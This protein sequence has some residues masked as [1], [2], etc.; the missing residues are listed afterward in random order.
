MRQIASISG[1][2]IVTSHHLITL[3]YSVEIKNLTSKQPGIASTIDAA[4]TE[5][6]IT[7]L[8]PASWYAIKIV[9]S[10]SAG[11][12]SIELKVSTLTRD[13]CKWA[14]SNHLCIFLTP[15]LLSI[16]SHVF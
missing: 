12:Q 6:L 13:G 15:C 9:A 14:E 2:K 3:F 1:A 5:L 11:T 16:S 7:D 10:N 4:Q 8:E